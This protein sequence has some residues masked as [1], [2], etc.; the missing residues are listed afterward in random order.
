M[1]TTILGA[2]SVK[3]TADSSGL[4]T[5]VKKAQEQLKGARKSLNE[6]AASFAKWG[7][8][9]VAAAGSIG[10]AIFKMTATNVR[11]INNL[12]FA[13]NTL[14]ED[15]QRGA[16]AAKQF[17][18]EQQKYGD[19]LKDVNDRIGDFL[20]TSGG[21]MAQFFEQ[22]AP[23][24]G[25]TADAF[26][27]LSGQD[28]LGLF[29]KS[30]ED[31]NLSQAEMTFHMEAM[32][33]DATLLLPLFKDNA[34]ALN[35]LTEQAKNLG[36][37]LSSLEVT[38]IEQANKA[39]DAAGASMDALVQEVVAEFAP[40]VTAIAESFSDASGDAEDMGSTIQLM[41]D[42]VVNSIG[43][44]MD[45]VEGVNRTFKVL[46]RTVALVVLGIQEG[47]LR[48]AD[49]IV[50][51]PIEAVNELIDALNTLPWHNIDPVELTGFGDTIKS[52]LR[53]VTKAINLGVK[54]IDDILSE[55]MPSDILKDTIEK[56]KARAVELNGIAEGVKKAQES[57]AGGVLPS[58]PV[59]DDT[60]KILDRFKTEEQ[61]LSEKY[62]SDQA[63]L[64]KALANKELS[65][66]KHKQAL[67]KLEQE[68][69]ENLRDLRKQQV[70]ETG[71]SS[72]TQGI[73]DRFKT[74]E[75]L[76][77]EKLKND[78]A[79][80]DQSLKNKE[81]TQ[82][83]HNQ[84]MRDLEV[85]HSDALR[86]IKIEKAGQEAAA[87]LAQMQERFAAETQLENDK[88]IADQEALAANREAGLIADDEF[89]QL[90]ESRNAEHLQR[91][92]DIKRAAIQKEL[93]DAAD[94]FGALA[95]ITELGGKK[96][97][98][99]TRALSVTQAIIK[100]GESAVSAF[101][102]GMA[103]G[104]PFAP[105][106]AALYT[107]AS[108]A[109]TGKM[110]ASLKSGSKSIARPT[111]SVGRSGAAA[112]ST[113]TQQTAPQVQKRVDISIG[114]GFVSAE[115]VRELMNKINEQVGDGVELHATIGV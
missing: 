90:V 102:A 4:T 33:S 88:F 41:S 89:M 50:N 85:E 49:F 83:E 80:I 94:R 21:P 61:L 1:A 36:V 60:Q 82:A 66:E 6:N 106:T 19:I 109:N 114:G 14:T 23:K 67:L 101:A 52:E 43:L 16:F 97:E 31:A 24:V 77:S 12:S 35:E 40:V 100:G 68:H 57:I 69:A 11:E 103:T 9:G 113:A 105:A 10:A 47:M 59:S 56:A 104:G 15:F 30:L 76:L 2:L 44:V 63:Q 7:A 108:L 26:R 98:K 111:A 79:M 48:A 91:L 13:A 34:A 78:Q 3:I 45:A 110:I 64:D 81:I 39:L 99:A 95:T 58:V 62:A 65:E 17:G 28:A 8:A 86:A 112:G 20:Q 37:G 74:E 22:V 73:I 55:P 42:V 18:I 29:V 92:D 25:I 72:E 5:G 27:G 38:Q 46:G 51:R 107:A 32:A 93:S 70:D 115:Q 75:Q 54:D 84:I 71:V 53:I 87:L 96:T